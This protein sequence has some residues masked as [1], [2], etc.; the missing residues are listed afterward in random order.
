[1]SAK[2]QHLIDQLASLPD[3]VLDEVQ[4][5]VNDIMRWR[6]DGIF[7]LTDDERVS[8]RKGMDAV[9]RGEFVPDEEMAAF[10]RRHRP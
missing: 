4:E 2:R 9:R 10:Y 1:M 7:R 6:Q 8:V 5:S 3:D